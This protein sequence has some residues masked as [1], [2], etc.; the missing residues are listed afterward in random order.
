MNEDGL[1]IGWYVDSVAGGGRMVTGMM[2]GEEEGM[3]YG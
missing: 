2:V 1:I 3:L